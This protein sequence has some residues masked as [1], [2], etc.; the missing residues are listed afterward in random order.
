MHRLLL[1]T[2]TAMAL[3]FVEPALAHGPKAHDP[4]PANK[5]AAAGPTSVEQKPFGRA[6][7]PAK[8]DRTVEI[9]MTDTMR[10]KPAAVVVGLGE[11]IRFVHS[12]SGKIMHEMVIGTHAELKE[13]AELM[14]RFPD[15]EHD[16]PHMAHVPPGGRGEIVWQFNR[17][18]RFEFGCLIPGHFEAGMVGGITV[19]AP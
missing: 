3:S 16:E 10:F 6:G 11:T 12:N 17:A 2:F 4:K 9:E 8:V 13:H 7:D 15:M 5:R 1:P 14:R 18:G 19:I